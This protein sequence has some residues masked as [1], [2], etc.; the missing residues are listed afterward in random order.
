MTSPGRGN[1][2]GRTRWLHDFEK[3]K[4][5][6]PPAAPGDAKWSVTRLALTLAG[7]KLEVGWGAM[8]QGW[9]GC[10]VDRTCRICAPFILF[11]FPTPQ[12]VRNGNCERGCEVKSIRRSRLE[13]VEGGFHCISARGC[14][15]ILIVNIFNIKIKGTADFIILDL[16]DTRVW[17]KISWWIELGSN[18]VGYWKLLSYWVINGQIPNHLLKYFV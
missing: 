15:L 8:P 13:V 11:C 3:R 6:I 12:K 14:I 2:K 10:R 17:I 4:G 18:I 5:K 16:T 9:A 7:D 1:I